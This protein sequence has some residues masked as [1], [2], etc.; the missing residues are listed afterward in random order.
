[1]FYQRIAE[2]DGKGKDSILQT[3]Q[4]LQ[5]TLP[6]E[7]SHGENINSEVYLAGIFFDLHR[8]L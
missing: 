4:R 8:G 6:G 2:P 3:I 7:A 1:M 5:I